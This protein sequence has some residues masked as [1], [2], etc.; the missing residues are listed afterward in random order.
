MS[1]IHH[2]EMTVSDLARSAEFYGRLLPALGWKR[3]RPGTFQ[4]DGCE[5]YLQAKTLPAAGPHYGPR[6]VCFHAASR[7]E[8]D[9]IG[10]LLAAARER[11]VR[12]LL[13]TSRNVG[14]R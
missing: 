5:I 8:V 13:T 4:K 14:V 2:V 6:H 1:A 12:Q 3:P 10:A 9:R 7:A 11:G